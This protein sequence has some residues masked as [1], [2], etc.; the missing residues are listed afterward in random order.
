MP[1]EA[2]KKVDLLNVV[3]LLNSLEEHFNKKNRGPLKEFVVVEKGEDL[4]ESL[5]YFIDRVCKELPSCPKIATLKD[6]PQQ[7]KYIVALGDV[8]SD[9]IPNSTLVDMTEEI[10]D[11]LSTRFPEEVEFFEKCG[12]VLCKTF[13]VFTQEIVDASSKEEEITQG[14]MAEKLGKLFENMCDQSC[15]E[16]QAMPNAMNLVID[17]VIQSGGNFTLTTSSKFNQD[18]LVYDSVV[19]IA[20]A[21]YYDYKCQIARTLFFGSQREDEED[22]KF[23]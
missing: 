16:V 10:T 17:P 2:K 9:K 7:G 12:K 14:K 11:L 23:M 20:M 22:Y 6:E 5:N 8:L 15:K 13:K 1:L 21:S 3:K 19:I 4:K 18:L